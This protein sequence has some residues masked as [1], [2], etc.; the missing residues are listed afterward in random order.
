[1]KKKIIKI[2]GIILGILL[3]LL[4]I[5]YLVFKTN[6]D[7]FYLGKWYY[8]YTY[9]ENGKLHYTE[10]DGM[11]SYIELYS[12]NTYKSADYCD[13]IVD[14]GIWIETKKGIYLIN[15]KLWLYKNDKNSLKTEIKDG[16]KYL[17]KGNFYN[18]LIK[19]RSN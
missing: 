14:K 10:E 16:K 4:L 15:D 17:F 7:S 11:E 18:V 19:S 9:L 8:K 12:N 3:L 2:F 5:L 13:D 1:M 6:K